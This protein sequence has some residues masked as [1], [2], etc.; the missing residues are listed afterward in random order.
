MTGR[1]S[2]YASFWKR[3]PPTPLVG[4]IPQSRLMKRAHPDETQALRLARDRSVALHLAAQYRLVVTLIGRVAAIASSPCILDSSIA[5]RR[6]HAAAQPLRRRRASGTSR[7][8]ISRSNTS[9][10]KL[11]RLK[12]IASGLLIRVSTS[13]EIKLLDLRRAR[14]STR[15]PLRVGAEAHRALNRSYEDLP[16]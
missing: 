14:A 6:R 8:S 11:S 15:Y 13:T 5:R 7:S 1:A 3:C 16:S 10:K 9:R 2:S 12:S 4:A